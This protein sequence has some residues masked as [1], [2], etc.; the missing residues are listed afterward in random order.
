M[1][2]T[3]VNQKPFLGGNF[4]ANSPEQIVRIDPTMQTFPSQASVDLLKQLGV[5]YVVVDSSGYKNFPV[6]EGKIQSLGLHLLH[7][8]EAE[9]VYGLP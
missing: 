8:S 6:I 7:V 4:N 5:A 1:Y 3:L 2:D 9:Y